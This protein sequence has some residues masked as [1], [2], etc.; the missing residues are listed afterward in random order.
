MVVIVLL[1]FKRVEGV[2]VCEVV[3]CAPRVLGQGGETWRRRGRREEYRND[4]PLTDVS[5]ESD[6]EQL[7]CAPSLMS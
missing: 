2:F 1:I 7:T 5:Q 4:D 3:V 6:M